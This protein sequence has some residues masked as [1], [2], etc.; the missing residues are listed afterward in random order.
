MAI[1][2]PISPTLNQ[3]Y[4]Y[5]GRTWIWNGN[6]WNLDIITTANLAFNQANAAFVQANTDNTVPTITTTGN[7]VDRIIY[8][9][10]SANS[11]VCDIIQNAGNNNDS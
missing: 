6:S 9:V 11:Y 10:R 4:S 1:N 7:A 3:S 2:F 8:T 5:N